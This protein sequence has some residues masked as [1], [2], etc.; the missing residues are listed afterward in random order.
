M[1]ALKRALVGVHH[2]R[3]VQCPQQ[4]DEDE[5]VNRV[6]GRELA[7]EG[8]ILMCAKV[9]FFIPF[10]SIS[11]VSLSSVKIDMRCLRASFWFGDLACCAQSMSA[12]QQGCRR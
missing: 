12:V 7:Q 6:Q 4:D 2:R 9:S 5:A 10:H 3:R 11:S 1:L 8:G